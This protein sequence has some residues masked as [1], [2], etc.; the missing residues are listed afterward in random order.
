MPK[1]TNSLLIVLSIL[2]TMFCYSCREADKHKDIDVEIEGKSLNPLRFDQD[3]FNTDWNNVQ[4]VSVLKSKYGMFFCLYLERILNAGPCDSL[5]TMQM[6]QGFVGHSD[7]RD[8]KTEIERN[9]PQDR[10]DSLQEK[11]LESAL[12]MQTLVPNMQLPQLIWMNSGFNIGSYSTD[13]Y[14]AVG[15]DFYL[16]NENRITKS[17]PFPQYQKDDMTRAQLVPNAIKNLAYFYLLKS[18]TIQ[19]ENDMLSEMIFHGKA[20]Y[21]TWLAFEEIQ[22]STLMAWTTKEYTWTQGHQLNV[23]KEIARQEVLFS[24]N[25][26]EVQKW[27]E[28][29]PFTNAENVPQESAPQLGVF[30]GFQMVRSYMEKHPEVTLDRLM[31]EDNAQKILQAYKPNL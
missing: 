14:L 31:K 19:H 9:Y 8:L 22:D 3:F 30:M 6:L 7:F 1:L 15:L 2:L 29:G 4:Q 20:H 25:R 10:L 16:G 26:V 28:Y 11:I 13:E 23:W 27:F 17:V 24:K 5:S 21:L 18:D 12:R